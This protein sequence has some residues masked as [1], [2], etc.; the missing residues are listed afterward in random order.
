MG[1]DELISMGSHTT[2]EEGHD[3]HVEWES[4]IRS[5]L[6]VFYAELSITL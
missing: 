3:Y 5:K 4:T 1:K 6:C 2:R